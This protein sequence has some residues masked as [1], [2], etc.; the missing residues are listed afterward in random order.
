[1]IV[2]LFL[3]CSVHVLLT[4]STLFLYFVLCFF[5]RADIHHELVKRLVEREGGGR[6]ISPTKEDGRKHG[7]RYERAGRN[8]SAGL[9]CFL[10]PGGFEA[11]SSPIQ[12]MTGVRG[13][14]E[15]GR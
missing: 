1:M 11:N 4:Y 2:F 14:A 8:A 9:T 6:G 15:R 12:G 7:Q 13:G 5:F 3:L 10:A